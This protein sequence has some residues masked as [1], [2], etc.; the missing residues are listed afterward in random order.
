LLTLFPSILTQIPEK[1]LKIIRLLDYASNSSSA[2]LLES[3][4]KEKQEAA[5]AAWAVSSETEDTWML[6][7]AAGS[8]L[9]TAFPFLVARGLWP[10]LSGV[11]ERTLDWLVRSGRKPRATVLVLDYSN[12]PSDLVE[13]VIA[14]NNGL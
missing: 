6:N 9:L 11:N 14:L 13:L 4:T 3:D 8:S 2:L 7:F 10:F 12:Y 5:A 1:A